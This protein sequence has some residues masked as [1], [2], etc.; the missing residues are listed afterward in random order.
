MVKKLVETINKELSGIRAKDYVA[1]I[2]QHHRIQASPGFR[3]AAK[4]VAGL[5][6]EFGLHN[7][8]FTYPGDGETYYWVSLNPKEWEATD[9]ILTLVE[10][11]N[12]ILADYQ[13]H[14]LSL[15]QRSAPVP[16]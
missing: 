5:L 2:I 3:A 10:P 14:K 1:E 11:E 16:E 7:E 6:T 13:E 8:I 4:Y 12:R 15:I 9:A